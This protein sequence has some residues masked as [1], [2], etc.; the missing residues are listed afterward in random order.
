M[1]MEGKEI[2]AELLEL[3]KIGKIKRK[4][5]RGDGYSV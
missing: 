1:R 5:V 3:K 2:A 4:Y